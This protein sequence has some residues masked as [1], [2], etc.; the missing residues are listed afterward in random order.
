VATDNA[1]SLMNANDFA[2]CGTCPPVLF[3]FDEISYAELF[4][5]I[6]VVDHTHAVICSVTLVKLV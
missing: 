3:L 1:A 4:Y 2:A 5:V 6:K